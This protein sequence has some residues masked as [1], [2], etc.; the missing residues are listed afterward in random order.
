MS[1]I[2]ATSTSANSAI[3]SLIKDAASSGSALASQGST[4][5]SSGVSSA[6]SSDPVD[7]VDLSDRAKQILARAKSE[8]AAGDKLNALLQSLKNPDSKD[9]TS[10]AQ[11]DDGTSLFDKLSGRAQTQTSSDTQWVAGAPYGNASIS[12]AD[13][14]KELHLEVYADSMDAAGL[15]PEAGQALR[16]AVA[17][18]TL[19]FQK[20]SDVPDLNFHSQHIFTTNAFGTIDSWGTSS[21]NPTGAT[22]DAIDQGKAIAMWSAD[23]GDI[24]ITW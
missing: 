24:Y 1:T 17:N 20:T 21:Q 22:K 6:S 23:R 10:K 15:P 7:T 9:T 12:D 19:K 14:T 2:S 8:Q 11:T 4:S 3:A 13:F 16:N 5:S 18:G